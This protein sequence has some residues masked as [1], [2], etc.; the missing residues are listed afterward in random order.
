ML[1]LVVAFAATAVLIWSSR[2]V[3]HYQGSAR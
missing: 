3:V 2:R 1:L